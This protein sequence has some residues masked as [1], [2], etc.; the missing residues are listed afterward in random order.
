MAIFQRQEVIYMKRTTTATLAALLGYSIFGFSFLFSKLALNVATPLV[1]ISVRFLVAF[2]VLNLLLLSGKA[3]VS[4]GGK[5]VHRLL[6]LGF[7]Q[8]VLY[9][10]LESYGIAMTSAALSGLMIGT[11]PVI[12]LIFGVLFL[13]ERCTWLQGVCTVLSVVGVGLTT[14]GGFG[15][16][17]MTG[18]LL[19]LATAVCA[20]LFPILSRSTAAYFTAFERTYVMIGLGSVVFTLGALFQNRSDLRALVVPLGHGTFWVAV[21]YLAVV[22]SVGAFLLLNYSL[23]HISA[24]RTL[25]FANFSTVMSILAGIFIMGDRFTPVQLVGILLI[26]VSIFGV[27][28]Q[29]ETAGA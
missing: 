7:V 16:T 9:F 14:T 18:F 27:S 13:R 19:L 1:L 26:T 25:I 21:L 29:K 17:S 22:S 5:P 8:P 15:G 2:L 10:V 3:Q 24:G 23:S 11:S 20:A 28:R 12:G 4:L 6:L